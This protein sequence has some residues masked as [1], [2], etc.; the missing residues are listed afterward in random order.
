MTT[1]RRESKT[2]LLVD[3]K[4]KTKQCHSRNKIKHMTNKNTRESKDLIS[5]CL[6]TQGKVKTVSPQDNNYI[7]IKVHNFS[8]QDNK[9]R[10]GNE[11]TQQYET[12]LQK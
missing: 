9:K 4:Q 2:F 12:N 5:V 3:K 8:Q 1:A 10:R 7:R 11:E 6:Q